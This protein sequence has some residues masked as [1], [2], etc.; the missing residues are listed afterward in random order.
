MFSLPLHPNSASAVSSGPL[1]KQQQLHIL[2]HVLHVSNLAGT[3]DPFQVPLSVLLKI[4]SE[5]HTCAKEWNNYSAAHTTCHN[6]IT[7]TQCNNDTL[8]TFFDLRSVLSV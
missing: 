7:M 1:K 2:R 6:R 5:S 4:R 8:V 3:V